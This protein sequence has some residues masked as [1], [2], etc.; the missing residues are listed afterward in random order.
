MICFKYLNQV[1]LCLLDGIKQLQL[2]VNLKVL[3]LQ[4]VEEC[5]FI[6]NIKHLFPVPIYFEEYNKNFH[7]TSFISNL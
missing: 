5:S 1:L 7:L 3:P 2:P 6:E 4:K